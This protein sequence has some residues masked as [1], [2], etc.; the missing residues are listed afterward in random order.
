MNNVSAALRVMKSDLDPDEVSKY[1]DL[2][3]DHAHQRGDPHLGREG[4][5]YADFTEGLWELRSAGG[6]SSLLSEVRSLLDRLKGREAALRQLLELGY[7]LDIFVGI[8]GSEEAPLGFS[9]PA[10]LSAALGDLGLDLELDIY[11]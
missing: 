4:R 10:D 11:P 2:S 7:R 6:E 3:P 1:L 9:I 5:R 8:F